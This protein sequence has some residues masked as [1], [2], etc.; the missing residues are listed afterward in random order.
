MVSSGSLLIYS[1]A[2]I[3]A[4][5]TV[6]EF[7][8]IRYSGPPRGYFLDTLGGV[9]YSARIPIGFFILAMA[10]APVLLLVDAATTLTLRPLAVDILTITSTLIYGSAIAL[11]LV[12]WYRKSRFTFYPLPNGV[13]RLIERLLGI[14]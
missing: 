6:V 2:A 1:V 10:I 13:R 3:S 7:I 5:G 9:V 8:N 12:A 11:I 14:K 4:T